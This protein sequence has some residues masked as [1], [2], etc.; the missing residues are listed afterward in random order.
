MKPKEWVISKAKY[1]ICHIVWSALYVV[2]AWRYILARTSLEALTSDSTAF[3]SI[4][5][6]F[7]FVILMYLLIT[8]AYIVFGAKKIEEW[9]KRDTI[10]SVITTVLCAPIGTGLFIMLFRAIH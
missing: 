7:I 9:D 5:H 8:A 2:I 4:Y 6:T 1:H 3:D 10:Y